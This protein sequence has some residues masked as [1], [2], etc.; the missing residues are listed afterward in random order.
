L[1]SWI[2]ILMTADTLNPRC[3]R[4]LYFIL[5]SRIKFQMEAV[6]EI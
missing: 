5:N 2:L 4:P 3:S 1:I 6:K